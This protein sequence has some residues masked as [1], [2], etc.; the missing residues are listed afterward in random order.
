M[1]HCDLT[2]SFTDKER[3]KITVAKLQLNIA[4][5]K[6]EGENSMKGGYGGFVV[7]ST[8]TLQL[9]VLQWG[10]LQLGA[11][12]FLASPV[13][14][15]RPDVFTNSFLVRLKRHDHGLAEVVAKRNGFHNMGPV[16]RDMLETTKIIIL[17]I[18]KHA[19]NKLY[20]DINNVKTC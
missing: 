20:I 9:L 17:I 6:K 7:L 2:G 13:Q 12:L 5:W 19:R 10:I 15:A 16:S 1:T 8:C 14:A 4:A 11:N 18:E 3:P